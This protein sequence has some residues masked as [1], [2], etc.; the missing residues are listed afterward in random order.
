MSPVVKF[1]VSS[2][3]PGEAAGKEFQQARPGVYKA[4]VQK[5]LVNK[6]EGKDRRI[7]VTYKLA[8]KSAGKADGQWLTDYLSL[9]SEASVWKLDQFLLAFGFASAKKR[10]GQFNTD[11]VMGK[12]C[13]IR[14]K[15]DSYTPSGS[16]E[17]EYRAKIGA[18][19][20]ASGGDETEE[21]LTDPDDDTSSSDD[22]STEDT[23]ERW[24]E[25]RGLEEEEIDADVQA[26]ITEK[27]GEYGVD[28]DEFA[29]W[30]ETV[31][32]IDEASGEAEGGD[33][34]ESSAETV[35]YSEWEIAALR[36]ELK[37]RGLVS[38]GKRVEIVARLEESD[39]EGPFA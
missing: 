10:K 18:V 31:E 9:E 12:A 26:E 17:A 16:D 29:T 13:K 22:S 3:D 8:D 38:T 5:C 1:D 39:S 6:P 7:E 28:P 4:V 14:V 27:A 34:E 11:E 19:L 23:D 35:D 25:I 15:A 24:V 21:D 20:P 33:S 2:S 37:K 32:A 36:A 30:V